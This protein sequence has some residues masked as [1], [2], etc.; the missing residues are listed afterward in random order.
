MA[1]SSGN[2][3]SPAPLVALLGWLVPGSG[4][5]LIG[6]KL[7]GTVIGVTIIVMF[8]AGILIGGIRVIDV[9]GYDDQGQAQYVRYE[10][11]NR[12]VRERKSSNPAGEPDNGEWTPISNWRW[13]LR[14]HTFPEVIN[15][16]WFIGQILSGPMCLGAAKVSLSAANPLSAIP[17]S[18]ARIYEIGTLYT[19]VAGMLNL[20]AIID[21]AYRAGQG[22]RC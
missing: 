9:P 18:H 16:P 10:Q 21:S 8:V 2:R 20:L 14:A 13:S 12:D 11:H 1:E 5:W 19:A 7:R 17:R 4:Y 15:K 22:A 3:F 6:H